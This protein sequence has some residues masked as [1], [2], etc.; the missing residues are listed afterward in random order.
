M[1]MYTYLHMYIFTYIH[2][3]YMHVN[4]S[5]LSFGASPEVLAL[6]SCTMDCQW[7][8]V[9]QGAQTLLVKILLVNGSYPVT[10]SSGDQ[11]HA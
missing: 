10:G 11:C 3:L 9:M 7:R 5:G 2:I 4:K 1:Y 6:I 8:R